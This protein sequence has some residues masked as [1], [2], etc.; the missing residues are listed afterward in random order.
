SMMTGIPLNKISSKEIDQLTTMANE[1][2]E[3]VIGQN[4]AVAKVVK[5]LKRNR[6]GIKDEHKPIG[7]FI[8]LGPTGVGKTYLAKMLA[9]YVFGSE[10]ALVRIDMSEYQHSFNVTKLI[11]SPPGYVGHEKGGQ[12][13]EIIRKKPYAVVLLDEIEK[14]HPDVF[15]TLLQLLDEGHLTDGLGRKIDFKNT[16]IIMTSNIGIKESMDFGPSV[17]FET[18]SSMGQDEDRIHGILEKALK[19]KFP[20]EFL[21]RIDDT[22]IFNTLSKDDIVKIIRLELNKL[23]KRVEGIGYK[24]V[25]KDSAIQQIAE[26]GYDIEYGARPL[27]RAIQDLI[28]DELADKMLDGITKVGDTLTFTYNKTKE[29]IEVKVKK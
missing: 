15:K 14:A 12:L 8:F 26:V 18:E 9:E 28:Q 21:N 27:N 5:A 7:S 4:K 1:M 16:L 13:T 10:D 11:G 19:K 2:E 23:I 25:I 17:G 3:T 20:P 24:M 6:L 29:K 22:I